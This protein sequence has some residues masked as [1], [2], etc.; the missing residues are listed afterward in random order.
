TLVL[1]YFPGNFLLTRNS[2]MMVIK[3]Q[4]VTTAR[5]KGLPP[6]RIRYAHAARNALLPLVTRFGL[7]LAFMVTGALIVE[8]IYSYPG[9]GTL[10]FNAIQAR[11]LPVIQGVVLISSLVVL[12]VILGLEIVYKIIDP[13]IEYAR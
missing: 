3:A 11:D 4:F 2:M 10:L 12:A 7:R 9:L 6:R 1:A 8:R 5:A 13:R